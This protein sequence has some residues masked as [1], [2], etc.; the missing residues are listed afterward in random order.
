MS[1]LLDRLRRHIK[2]MAPHQ[3]E[4]EAGQLLIEAANQIADDE[5][6]L[7]CECPQCQT[8][9]SELMTQD[10]CIACEYLKYRNRC[11]QLEQGPHDEKQVDRNIPITAEL[12]P[13]SPQTPQKSASSSDTTSKNHPSKH[14]NSSSPSTPLKS[15]ATTPHAVVKPLTSLISLNKLTHNAK[16]SSS[17]NSKL[18]TSHST[19]PTQNTTRRTV[20][21]VL[22]HTD[23]HAK[24]SR[25]RS[26]SLNEPRR[27]KSP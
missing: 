24:S 15:T 18:T 13:R 1:D 26:V 17:N 7:H 27:N 3:R 9:I 4:R 16:N 5:A 2:I 23:K 11:Q 25:K 20:W 22:F 19:N 6:T 21:N 14:N 8:T 10:G 12:R